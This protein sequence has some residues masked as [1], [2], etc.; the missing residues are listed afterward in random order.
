M[1]ARPLGAHVLLGGAGADLSAFEE[2]QRNANW[3]LKLAIRGH[4]QTHI[5]EERQGGRSSS[6]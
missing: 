5:H 2:Q 6:R 4:A 1:I 3:V